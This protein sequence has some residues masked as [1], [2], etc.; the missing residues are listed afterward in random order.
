MPI[1]IFNYNISLYEIII[2][3]FVNL[4]SKLEQSRWKIFDWDCLYFIDCRWI[5]ENF[6]RKELYKK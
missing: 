4:I 6:G 2:I 3:K 5:N 1:N